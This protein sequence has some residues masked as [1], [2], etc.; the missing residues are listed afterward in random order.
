VIPAP[1]A[2][3]TGITIHVRRRFPVP[4]EKVFRAWTDADV[5][6][7]WWCPQGWA[8]AEIEINARAGGTYRIGMRRSEPGP[9]IYVYGRFLEVHP[10][11][12]LVYTWQWENAF[13]QMP[14]TR[15]TVQFIE[16]GTTTEI[17]LTHEN[18]PEISVC[19]RHRAGWIAAWER[20][21]R[22]LLNG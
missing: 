13:E 18:L 12:R 7:R 14:Q 6:K 21:E 3:R 16:N 5:L 20:I 22:S 9:P 10:P 19:L 15:V 1:L 4:R 11:E 17:V 2:Q 8:P